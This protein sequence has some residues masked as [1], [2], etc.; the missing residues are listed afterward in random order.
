MFSEHVSQFLSHDVT[1]QYRCDTRRDDTPYLRISLF[2][3]IFACLILIP[4][5]SPPALHFNQFKGVIRCTV[6]SPTEDPDV[7]M[8]ASNGCRTI[9]I[10][11]VVSING[12]K[13]LD[14]FHLR[15]NAVKDLLFT[16]T[17]NVTLDRVSATETN[18]TCREKAH[19]LLVSP[20]RGLY[21]IYSS[22]WR[23]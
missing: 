17:T 11:S 5:S 10:I 21:V 3:P 16:L 18:V 15:A 7:V 23:F 2:L 13:I 19:L 22:A 1:V 4:V 14:V 6:Q 9:R 20:S 12:V 8:V